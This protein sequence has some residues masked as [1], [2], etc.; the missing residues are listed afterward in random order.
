MVDDKDKIRE[1]YKAGKFEVNNSGLNIVSHEGKKYAVS[2]QKRLRVVEHK[3]KELRGKVVKDCL[4][5]DKDTRV[6]AECGAVFEVSKFHPYLDK[7]PSC[8]RSRKSAHDIEKKCACGNTFTASKFNPNLDDCPE[9]RENKRKELKSGK[10]FD[11]MMGKAD[12]V[13]Q[14]FGVKV[15]I[16]RVFAHDKFTSGV[17]VSFPMLRKFVKEL[18]EVQK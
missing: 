14:E 1:L 18:K 12:Q 10:L 4:L 11:V 13:A 2:G 9:C 6:C 5:P 3:G 7:C 17:S 8:R 15:D 16:L